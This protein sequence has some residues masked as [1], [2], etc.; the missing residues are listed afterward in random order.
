MEGFVAVVASVEFLTGWTFLGQGKG[1]IRPSPSLNFLFFEQ[2]Q[3][4]RT[5]GLPSKMTV[6]EA[7]LYTVRFFSCCFSQ[8]GLTT[9]EQWLLI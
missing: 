6:W 7:S 2:F 4:L 8:T 1:R 5:L 9:E 3:P